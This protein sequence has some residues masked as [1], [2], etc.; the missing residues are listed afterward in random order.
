MKN[1]TNTKIK[2]KTIVTIEI[3]WD[4]KI[5]SLELKLNKIGLK[6]MKNYQIT[7]LSRIYE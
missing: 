4:K 3:V 7:G 5:A 6:P 2:S 1:K